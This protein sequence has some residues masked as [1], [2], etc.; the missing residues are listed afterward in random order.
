MIEFV[1]GILCDLLDGCSHKFMGVWMSP[2]IVLPDRPLL[3]L[4]AVDK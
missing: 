4:G 2:D 1:V 3:R